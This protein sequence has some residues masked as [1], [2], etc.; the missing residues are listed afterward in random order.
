MTET[1]RAHLH[2][3]LAGARR[4][5]VQRLDVQVEQAIMVGDTSY[6]L[7]MAQNIAMPRVGVSYGVHSVEV[8]QRYQPLTIADDVPSLHDFLVQQYRLRQA[9]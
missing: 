6:D 3:H 8:L 7:E 1:R 9:S 4:I 5:E 2:Q